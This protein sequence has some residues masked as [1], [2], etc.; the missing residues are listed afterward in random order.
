VSSSSGTGILANGDD[1]DLFILGDAEGGVRD[2]VSLSGGWTAAGSLST[3]ALTGA[4][5]TFD[6]YQ[7]NGAQVAVQQGL[8]QLVA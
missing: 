3:A 2:D 8:D 1:L 5:V 7:S 4:M 6:L